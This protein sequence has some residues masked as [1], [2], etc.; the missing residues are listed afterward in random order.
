MHVTNKQQRDFTSGKVLKNLILFAIPMAIAS[1]LQILFNSADVA[2]VGQFGGSQ[3]QAAVG[4]TS[5]TVH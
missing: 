4:A 1:I 5:S 3:Y 2:I